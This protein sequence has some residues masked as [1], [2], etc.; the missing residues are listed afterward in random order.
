MTEKNPF[1]GGV[2]KCRDAHYGNAMLGGLTRTLRMKAAIFLAAFYA[3]AML[4]PHA[5]LAFNATKVLH[6]LDEVAA[7][8]PTHG[9]DEAAKLH[10]HGKVDVDH[11]HADGAADK[12]SPPIAC[13]GLFSVAAMASDL[14]AEF[15][16]SARVTAILPLPPEPLDGE[17]PGNISK[18]PRA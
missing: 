11:D 7:S 2:C 12:K 10:A 14:R 15:G 17:G 3:F 16:I 9:H 18:P 8:V 5:A 4:A 6:C 1:L 13:C